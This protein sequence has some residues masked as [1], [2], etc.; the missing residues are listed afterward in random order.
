MRTSFCKISETH[1]CYENKMTINERFMIVHLSEVKR[2]IV[3][4]E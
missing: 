2:N 3:Y 4:P 1:I